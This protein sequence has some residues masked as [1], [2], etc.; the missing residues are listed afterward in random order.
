[1]VTVGL[2]VGPDVLESRDSPHDG[3]KGATLSI[4]E[5]GSGYQGPSDERVPPQDMSAEQSVLGSMLLNK[6]AI[7]ESLA[8]VKGHDFYRPAHESIFEAILDLFGRGEPA[9]AITVADELTK[10]GDLSRVGGASYLHEL[11]QSVPTA[12]NASYYAE[13]VH[14]RAVLRRL[15]EAGTRIVQMGYGQGE[16]D[17]ED[18][19]NRAQAEVYSVAE[20]RG[21]EDYVVLSEVLEQT[22]TEIEAAAGRTD[23]MIGVPTG[24]L[25]LDELTHGLHPGQM[26]V[27]AARPAVGK[28]LALDTPLPTPDGWTTM[29]AVA[30]GDRLLGADGRPTT[31]VA[32]TDVLRDRPC[33]EVE[34]SDGT[35]IVADAEHQWLTDTRASRKSFQA[36]RDHRNRTRNQRTFAAVRTTREIADTL[37]TATREARLNHSVKLTKP[38]DLPARDLLLPP[39]VLGAWLG[40]GTS[41]AAQITT[42][43]AEMVMRL[44]AEGLVVT[45]TAAPMRYSLTL[46]VEAVSGRQC[47][48]CGEPFTPRTNQVK[49]CGGSCGGKAKGTERLEARCG[50]CG[51]RCTGLARC[52]SCRADHGTFKALLRKVGVLG[53]KHIPAD[54]QRASEAQRRE[55]L[56]G[57]LDTDGTVTNGG[58]AQF[59][60]TDQRLHE[61][62]LELIHGLGYRTGVS[63]KA[64][65][66]RRPESSVAFTTTFSSDDDV[67]WLPRKV[68]RHKELR[69]RQFQRRDSRFV[70]AVRP[71]EPVPVRCV[72]VDNDDHLYLASRSMVPTHNSTLGIDIA[73]S[74]AIKHNLTTAVFSLEMSRTEITM[75]ILSAEATIQLQDL[76]KGLKGQEQ[77]NK[78]ARIMGKI[79]DAP[80]FID[81]SPNM[82]LMEIRAKARRLKQ[83]HN[84]KLVVIDY[85]QLMSSGKKVESRQQEV[86]EFSRALKLLAKE[87]EVPVIAISQLNRG[88]E[89]RTDKRPQM[90]DLRESGCLPAETRILRA[91]TGAEVTIGEL[92]ASGERDITV[93]ALDDG[94]RYTK[95]TM[96]HAFSTGF[97]PVF[98]LT[99]ASG[100]T[101]RATENHPFLTYAGWSPLA[102][103]RTGDRVAVPRHVP[104]PLLVA[105]WEDSKVVLLAHL[106][107]DGSF[108]KRQPI[109]YASIDEANLEAVTKAALVFGVAAA[110]DDYAAA[111]CTTL[112]LHAP[113]RLTHGV[114]NPIA[115]WLDEL[116]LFGLRSHEKFVPGD[117]FCLP[118]EQI[119]LFIRHIWAT[120]GSVTVNKS[121]R[122]GRIYYGSTS[123]RL[124]DDLSRLLLRFGIQ[125]R[126]RSV[127]KGEYRRNYT[128]DIS[129]VDSQRR[130]LQEI[131][132]HGER[133]VAAERLLEIVRGLT[134]NTNVD[135]VPKQVWDDVREEMSA[136]GMTARQFQSALGTQYCGSALYASAP[137][138][139]RLSRVAE[140]LDS[141]ALELMATNDVFWDQVVSVE[142]EGIEE[143]Y[144]ATV[145]DC[146][147]FVAEGIAVHNSIEQDADVVILL[148][149][150]RSDPERDGEADVIVAKHRNG[151]TKDIVLAFQGHYSRF[152]NMA[153]EGGF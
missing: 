75:R 63:K 42:A 107:G 131:G 49:T 92:A 34:F 79:G 69:A 104:S 133:G 81:D 125:T 50:D 26:I 151:P 78:L 33:F 88:P 45:P 28:A 90:S 57:L 97:A 96:T 150:D 6:D 71:I 12:A 4:A 5:L 72:E 145:L 9:D 37:R 10:R 147:N 140:V 59:T 38:L 116:G 105:D 40:D 117:V 129:G 66:G 115:A 123:R 73:R 13:I 58:C 141:A 35:V 139:A 20:K 118:K 100:K 101:V 95:R 52:Q 98:R 149:R 86:A 39:Y 84:L 134:A 130:F 102:S 25:E 2:S 3:S 143:V 138:R 1:M 153:R 82:S 11:V 64:V 80:L 137:S 91:D 61:D 31:V 128:L 43:D 65:T 22:L 18:I 83:Q 76:R 19:V 17:V 29:G 47:V 111:R 23:E 126:I 55:L 60:T 122:G 14:E 15:V 103:L 87:L 36:A 93:W 24:F 41:Q 114:R 51:A 46:P 99:L 136:Q 32:A 119:A 30:V 112:R 70:V 67:F 110:R 7:A 56:A 53:N 120:D 144:D 16:G 152:N 21:G 77:W 108:V 146:H 48:V 27:V 8:L 121:G 44:E 132:V 142:A 124:I 135:T 106:L 74:A 54:Y 89:Q 113:F 127:T 94:L 109:R 68:L 148:H 62:V 85:L